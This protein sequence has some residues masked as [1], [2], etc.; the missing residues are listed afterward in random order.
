MKTYGELEPLEGLVQRSYDRSQRRIHR[1][2]FVLVLLQGAGAAWAWTDH[3]NPLW[4]LTV[5]LCFCI[6]C[7]TA[8]QYGYHSYRPT[9]P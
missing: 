7:M 1:L 5:I 3:H 8:Y 2:T 6:L 4:G 9:K